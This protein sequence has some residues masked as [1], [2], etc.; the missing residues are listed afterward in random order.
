MATT[1]PA[2]IFPAGVKPFTERRF[3]KSICMFDVD[4][5]LTPARR[6]A[7]PEMIE[8]M[9]KL[10]EYTATAFVSGSDLVKIQDQLGVGGLLDLDLFMYL[11]A[12][13]P[14]LRPGYCITN[15]LDALPSSSR[16][17]ELQAVCLLD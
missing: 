6:D 13:Y 14:S 15:Q 4:G 16:C 10:R 2:N 7:T 5:T 3:P 9:R 11:K 1:T 12:V 17:A 8:A